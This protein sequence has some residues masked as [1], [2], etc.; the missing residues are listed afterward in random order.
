[1]LSK[2]IECLICVP[3]AVLDSENTVKM[4]K[5]D[6]FPVF[7]ILEPRKVIISSFGG[8]HRYTYALK[9]TA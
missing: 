1:M 2:Y 4:N 3:G 6:T 7:T 5:I 8:R 9:S